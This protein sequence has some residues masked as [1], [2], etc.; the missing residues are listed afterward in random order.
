MKK[1][2]LVLIV[3]GVGLFAAGCID[4]IKAEADKAGQ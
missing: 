4:Q 1:L 2:S 3:L